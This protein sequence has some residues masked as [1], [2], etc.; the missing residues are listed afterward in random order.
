MSTSG[1]YEFSRNH[2]WTVYAYYGGSGL[3][4]ITVLVKDWTDTESKHD[5]YNW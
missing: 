4:L 2:T 1:E 3:E 5:V